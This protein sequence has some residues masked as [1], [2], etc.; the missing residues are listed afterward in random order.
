MK[1]N[2]LLLLSLL[3]CTQFAGA[4]NVRG[5]GSSSSSEEDINDYGTPQH[6][7]REKRK[8]PEMRRRG[9]G[10]QMLAP[11]FQFTFATS[12][13]ARAY[14]LI[15]LTAEPTPVTIINPV[16]RFAPQNPNVRRNLFQ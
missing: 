4:M 1:N 14:K 7:G 10:R 5:Y 3:C 2:T 9:R 13:A 15:H 11:T 8:A 12:E 16:P 6:D